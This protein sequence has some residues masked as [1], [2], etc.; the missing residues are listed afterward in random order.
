MTT[1]LRKTRTAVLSA[2]AA[3]LLAVTGTALY[4]GSSDRSGQN[5]MWLDSW[6]TAQMAAVD[7]LGPNWSTEGFADHTIRQTVRPT[8]AGESVRITLSNLFGDRPLSIAAATIAHTAEGAAVR[9]GTVRPLSFSGSPAAVIPS[10]TELTSDAAVYPVNARQPITV[11][12]Y[13]NEATGP[14]TFHFLGNTT[15]YRAAGDHSTD[16]EGAAFTESDKS[17]YYL[18]GIEV[19]GAPNRDGVVTFG[20]SLTDGAGAGIDADNR[21]P[22][23][24]ADRLAVT[25]R[26]RAV[27]NN[28]IGGNRIVSDSDY[29]GQR[30]ATRFRRDVLDKDGIGTVILLSGINDIGASELPEPWLRPNPEVT[31]DQLIAEYQLLIQMARDDG[32][33]VIGG[34]LLPY[35]GAPYYS[36][37]GERVRDAVNSWIRSSGEFDA[38]IDFERA[39][40]D[41]SDPDSLA[42]QFDSGDHLHPGP[43]GYS[44]MAEAAA[45]VLNGTDEQSMHKK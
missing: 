44:A 27:L 18:A 36:E 38:V 21:Y 14:A 2:V 17:W 11:T 1:N 6:S 12:L 26:P 20:D 45:L 32:L 24:L 19:F 31:A 35:R 42:E 22:D 13:L 33:R 10:G 4:V 28:G 9:S 7:V 23:A 25:D 15:T 39:L 43:A 41:P 37:R 34:T 3:L 30:A 29:V 8:L 40:A 16:I 5:R